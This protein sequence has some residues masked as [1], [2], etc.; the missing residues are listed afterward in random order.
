MCVGAYEEVDT[1]L[2]FASFAGV[3]V[4]WQVIV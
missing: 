2:P 4:C 1:N 3:K